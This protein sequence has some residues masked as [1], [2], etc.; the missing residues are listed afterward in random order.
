MNHF[1]E[2]FRDKIFRSATF[3]GMADENGFPNEE[4]QKH[5]E[6]L[7]EMGVKNIITGFVYVSQDGRAVHLGQ[8]GMDSDDKIAKYSK[9]TDNVHKYDSK[10]YLQIA[11]AGRQTSAKITKKEVVGAS[12]KASKYFRS[13]PKKLSAK[14]INQIIDSFS[15]AALRAKISGF[16]GVQLHA[17]HG[18]LIHQFLHP[19]I[20]TRND[21][22]GVNKQTGI[23]DFF[24][25]KLISSIKEKCGIDY[26]ILVKIS[27]SDILSEPFSKENFISLIKLLDEEKVSGIEISFGTME[28]ALNIFR[29]ESVPIDTILKYNF[30]YKTENKLNRKFRK[31]FITHFLRKK[32]LNFS[33]MYNLEYAKIAKKYTSIPIICVGGFR[34]GSEIKNA[35]ENH[36]TDFLSLCRPFICEPDFVKKLSENPVYVSQCK[37]CNLCAIMC[38]SGNPTKCYFKFPD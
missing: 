18:Y 20:N 32:V 3:E 5:Y 34:K 28:N 37:N 24:L 35:L 8:A 4:Y 1:E 14:E 26:P 15:M 2:N 30:H 29:S 38:D 11:H 19:Y 17:A 36:D 12:Q 23:G 31:F 7:A 16:D 10:I 33:S 9:V 21:E 6:R 25:R 22:F 13:N 27:A